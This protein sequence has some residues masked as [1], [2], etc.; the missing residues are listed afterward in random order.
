MSLQRILLVAPAWVGDMVM[1][2]PLTR[3]LKARAGQIEVDV[4]APRATLALANRMAAVDASF[5]LNLGHGQLQLGTRYAF[6]KL[7][8]S[9]QYQQAIVLPNTFKSALI[10]FWAKIPRRSGWQGESRFVVLNDRRKL[11]AARY[12][13]MV[14]RYLAL[15]LAPGADVP[16]AEAPQLTVDED[17]L[18]AC[19]DSLDITLDRP[20]LAL[21]PGAEFGPSKRWPAEHYAKVAHAA[22]AAGKQVWLLGSSGD[23]QAADEIAELAD[24]VTDLVGRTS[25]P[26]V[27]DLLSVAESVVTNDS[28]LMHIACAVGSRVTA[29]FGSS[30]SAHT[31]PLSM[32]ATALSEPMDCAPCYERDCP[33]GHHNCMQQLSP[34]RVLDTLALS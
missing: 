34:A 17:N 32:N 7:L 31:P 5:E 10:P 21:C 26:D 20:V 22:L 23:R 18:K 13:L 14:Q 12:P 2:E 24:G 6:G 15:G 25:L 1:A 8:R 3:L 30:S 28:G 29:L 19:L 9:G 27:I 4:L 11:D 33:L 16:E